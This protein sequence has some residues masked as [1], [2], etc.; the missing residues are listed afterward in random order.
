MTDYT[1]KIDLR[2]FTYSKSSEKLSKISNQIETL[3]RNKFGSLILERPI[4]MYVNFTFKRK[5]YTT[6]KVYRTSPPDLDNLVKGILNIMSGIAYEDD[7]DV[8]A[9]TAC[10][11]YGCED[12]IIINLKTI[13]ESEFLAIR[14]FC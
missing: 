12:A 14:N 13:D 6:D 1:L 8:V 3:W 4:H 5:H 2:P 10:K 7:R 9:Y 11:Y